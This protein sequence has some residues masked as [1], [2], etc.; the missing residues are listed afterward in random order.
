MIVSDE[1]IFSMNSEVNTRYV[2]KYAECGHGH[3]A[4]HYVEFEQGPDKIMVWV[5]IT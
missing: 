2:I 4:E 3:P 5:G 1:A